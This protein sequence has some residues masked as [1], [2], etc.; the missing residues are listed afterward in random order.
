MGRRSSTETSP[1]RAVHDLELLKGAI[2]RKSNGNLVN[3]Y[4][5]GI[6]KFAHRHKLEEIPPEEQMRWLNQKSNPDKQSLAR[7]AV[8]T[9][10]PRAFWQFDYSEVPGFTDAVT[11]VRADPQFRNL[12]L[13]EFY[14]ELIRG[15]VYPPTYQ[16]ILSLAEHPATGPFKHASRKQKIPVIQL[17]LTDTSR[18]RTL[19]SDQTIY[20]PTVLLSASRTTT[21]ESFNTQQYLESLKPSDYELKTAEL[22]IAR[23]LTL[24]TTKELPDSDGQVEVKYKFP[25]TDNLSEYLSK[26]NPSQSPERL[27]ALVNDTALKASRGYGIAQ[28]ARE[29]FGKYPD[30]TPNTQQFIKHL[31]EYCVKTT[32]RV[33]FPYRGISAGGLR[34]ALSRQMSAKELLTL[35]NIRTMDRNFFYDMGRDLA[36]QK[37]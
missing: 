4:F 31:E 16:N 20:T 21:A 24:V 2:D 1:E 8:A 6:Q 3:K 23:A 28:A 9:H 10:N 15:S 33:I 19:T 7:I 32:E 36:M 17:P 27:A 5:S 22:S 13:E 14:T 11:I 30:D 29:F 18:A 26:I 12:E 34:F 25:R 35:E 37:P